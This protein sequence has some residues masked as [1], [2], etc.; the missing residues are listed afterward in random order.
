MK[1]FLIIALLFISA[2]LFLSYSPA[3]THT[4]FG[5]QIYFINASS[6]D[7]YWEFDIID[8]SKGGFG[9]DRLCLEEKD[10]VMRQHR[11]SVR[12]SDADKFDKNSTD[13]NNYLNKI[14]IYDMKTGSLLIELS[15]EKIIFNHKEGSIEKCDAVYEM[16]IDNSLLSGGQ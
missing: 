7:L 10:T 1:R 9:N 4:W 5:G 13:P 3:Q 14:R 15:P 8:K 16:L 2:F 11:Y 6:Y 12:I